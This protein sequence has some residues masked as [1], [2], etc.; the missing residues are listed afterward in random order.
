MLGESDKADKLLSSVEA[1]RSGFSSMATHIVDPDSFRQVPGTPFAY[2]VTEYVRRLFSSLNPFEAR[3]R[4]IRIGMKTGNDFRFLRAWWE[5]ETNDDGW[6]PFAKGGTARKFY[7]DL[8]LVVDWHNEGREVKQ[9]I[10]SRM[11]EMFGTP[12]W[13]F[14]ISNS[15]LYF[16][17]GLTWPLR[18]AHFSPFALPRGCIFSVRGYAILA[19]EAELPFLLG[20]GAS[21][22]FDYL[23]RRL[24]NSTS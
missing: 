18:A 5:V 19:P 10:A 12:N 16:K 13:E 15:S 3:D 21:S 1:V 9:F 7:A 11:V 14:W 20:L 6:V 4:L 24:Q 2:W 8:P 22:L 23:F 17:P